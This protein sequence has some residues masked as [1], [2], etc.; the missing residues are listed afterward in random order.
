MMA[1]FAILAVIAGIAI[2]AYFRFIQKAREAAVVG[3]LSKI[4]T[5]EEAYVINNPDGSYTAD[6]EE[7]GFPR[8]SVDADRNIAYNNDYK[9]VLSAGMD[10]EEKGWWKVIAAPVDGS[11]DVRWFYADQT[12]KIRYEVGHPPGADSPV[13]G[14]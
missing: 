5:V 12:G 10:S 3:F 9:F 13:V 2:L 8:Q 1:V 6:F 11:A 4:A 7:L 14:S